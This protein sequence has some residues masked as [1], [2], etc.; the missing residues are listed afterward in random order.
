MEVDD[1]KVEAIWSWSTPLSIHDVR[2]FHGLAPFYKRF[3]RNFSTIMTPISKVLKDTS[4]K[5]TLKAQQAFE[6][7]KRKLT[8]ALVL[9][10]PCFEKIFE[11]E[12]D[13]SNV[14]IRGVLTQEGHPF[15]YFSEKLCD[16]TA[17][18]TK[19]VMP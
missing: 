18:M 2:S 10:L 9:A 7:I 17:H 14:G 13:A 4:F 16:S 11:V 1:S 12:C 19:N 6:E 15:A 8:Q 5:W 3:I